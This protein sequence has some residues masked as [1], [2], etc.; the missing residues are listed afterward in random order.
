MESAQGGLKAR[1]ARC[2]GEAGSRQAQV[3]FGAKPDLSKPEAGSRQ[4]PLWAGTEN[5]DCSRLAQVRTG[6]TG[7]GSVQGRLKSRL[8][9]KRIA[10]GSRRAQVQA[11]EK[12]GWGWLKAG[13][14]PPRREAKLNS[15]AQTRLKRRQAQMQQAQARLKSSKQKLGSA[16]GRLK[17]TRTGCTIWL[18]S[19]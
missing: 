8:P 5:R 7:P 14:S 12:A 16:Q 18:G 19:S 3:H 15:R 4:A 11:G 13:S 2:Q 10:S 1:L 6:K 17:C 9:G